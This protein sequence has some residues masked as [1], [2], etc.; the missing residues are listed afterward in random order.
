MNR[1]LGCIVLGITVAGATWAAKSQEAVISN[2]TKSE[3]MNMERSLWAARKSGDTARLKVLVD[4]NAVIYE[5]GAKRTGSEF[6]ERPVPMA[7]AQ[8][9]A[10]VE[11]TMLGD[12]AGIVI[13]V[14]PDGMSA[15][16][17]EMADGPQDVAD[18]WHR[19]NG[20]WMLVF[21]M[22]TL[23]APEPGVEEKR[24]R[25][26]LEEQQAAWNRGDIDSFMKGYWNSQQ[27]EFVTASGVVRGWQAV[28]D[29]YHKS[30]PGRAAMGSLAF[31]DL[32]IR[33]V[34]PTA[35]LVTGAF[36]L[37]RENDAPGGTFTLLFRRFAD[38]WKITGDHTSVKP[39]AK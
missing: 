2:D 37:Q 24:I 32:E 10:D 22:R 33:L 23:L 28:L 15:T 6:A 11:A 12:G 18:T 16:G 31:S 19:K 20:K 38:G 14:L 1:W 35:A 26:V 36:Q 27:T 4:A 34:S 29:R 39:A 13:Y 17:E 8:K 25:G 21:E 7:R 3:L 5:D 30:Y 9:R